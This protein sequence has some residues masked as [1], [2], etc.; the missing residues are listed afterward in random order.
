M[1]L[2][3]TCHGLHTTFLYW[4]IQLNVDA[5]GRVQSLVWIIDVQLCFGL[6]YSTVFNNW[7]NSTRLEKMCNAFNALARS[8]IMSDDKN[9]LVSRQ[10]KRRFVMCI[11]IDAVY[12]LPFIFG[13]RLLTPTPWAMSGIHFM[14]AVADCLNDIY[15]LFFGSIMW[16][17]KEYFTSIRTLMGK[18][19]RSEW[20]SIARLYFDVVSLCQISF[21]SLVLP[22]CFSFLLTFVE[23]TST[24]FL[25]F[26]S[27]SGTNNDRERI[28]TF[29]LYTSWLIPL[30]YK[31]LATV[32]LASSASDEVCN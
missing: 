22:I 25:L 31:F 11:I 23:S 29:V 2:Y 15:F 5:Q 3:A 16:L 7:M 8:N 12:R 26:Q 20:T 4:Q 14:F 1:A 6:Y 17:T 21:K 30:M 10:L 9:N 13:V 32:S 19:V 24:S 18:G 28:T 27:L